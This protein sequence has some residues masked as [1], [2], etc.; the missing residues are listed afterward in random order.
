VSVLELFKKLKKVKPK[1]KLKDVVSEVCQ[2][3][4]IK[5]TSFW[6]IKKL[7]P[8]PPK[9]QNPRPK[10]YSFCDNDYQLIDQII[11]NLNKENYSVFINDVYKHMKSDPNCDISFKECKRSTFYTIIKRMGYK[12]SYNNKIIREEIVKTERI[13][14]QI[15]EYLI[16]KLRLEKIYSIDGQKPPSVFVDETVIHKNYVNKKTLQLMD[17]NLMLKTN[18]SV[19][20]G[21]RFCVINAGTEDGFVENAEKIVYKIEITAQI[22]E[23]WL[24]NQLMP[25]VPPNSVVIYD[26]CSVHSRKY[27]KTPTMASNL[28]SR[29]VEE[30]VKGIKLY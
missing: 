28:K 5:K 29:I 10:N 18:K 23:E 27:S 24:E 1:L 25:N 6:K 12:Y 3:F 17:T 21:V 22:F 15:K 7:G 20:K 26:N 14:K 8:S 2:T 9:K 19:G 4:G 30:R 16:E 11:V 13:Q